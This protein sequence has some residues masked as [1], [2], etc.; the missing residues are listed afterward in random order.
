MKKIFYAAISI[1]FFGGLSSC[2]KF[3]DN[4]PTSQQYNTGGY[5]SDTLLLKTA[6]DAENAMSAVYSEFKNGSSE[7]FFLDYYVNGDAHADNAYAGGDNPDNIQIDQFNVV[8][9]NGNV[10]RDW[11][12]YYTIISDCNNVI[13]NVPKVTDPGLSPTRKAEIIGEASFVRAFC[14]F[15]LLRLWGNVPLVLNQVTAINSGN[16]AKVYPNLYPARTSVDSI[17]TQIIAD[18][19]TT[20][21]QGPASGPT[22]FIG[23]QGAGNALMA[24]VYATIQPHDWNKVKQ[25]SDAVIGGGYTLLP[26][27]DQ[28]WDGIHENSSESIF[29]IDCTDWGTGGNWGLFIMVGT[30]Y[31]KFNEPSNDLLKAF[32]DE[33]DSIRKNSSISFADV[34]GL[35]T[36]KFWQLNNYPFIN[37]FR[38]FSGGQNQILIRLADIL[39]LKA[40][41]LNETNDIAGAAALIN[42]IRARV[43]LAPTTASTQDEMRL[44]IEKERRLELAFE[45]IRWYDLLRTGRA[46]AVINAQTDGNGANLGY[47]VTNE[48]L[49][50]PIPQSERDKNKNLTQN[51]GY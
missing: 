9:T 20:I 18:L 11:G 47:N 12:H 25:Y 29:E 16:I 31:K 19:Q 32:N 38:D 48:K 13:N 6:S 10:S 21:S 37:K 42:Q 50:W 36:D 45:G 8:S 15:D 49:I 17:Y 2:S 1:Y 33:G 41:A 27:Y 23:T 26:Q 4:K 30:D 24:K 14:Y 3:L 46:I 34:T 51:T 39:L 44:A 40:E 35:W 5:G 22:K 43:N 28:L 7:L